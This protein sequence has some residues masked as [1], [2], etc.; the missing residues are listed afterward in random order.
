MCIEKPLYLELAICQEA[1]PETSLTKVW[2]LSAR[3]SPKMFPWTSR[4]HL[5]KNITI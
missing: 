2:L 1:L 4:L 5:S 3:M